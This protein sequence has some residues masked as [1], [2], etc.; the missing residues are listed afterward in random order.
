MYMTS[1]SIAA[2]L[3]CLSCLVYTVLQRRYEKLQG[4]L[5]IAIIVDVGITAISN[6]ITEIAGPLAAADPVAAGLQ[7]TFDYLYFIAHSALAPLFCVYV[8]VVCSGSLRRSKAHNIVFSAPFFLTEVFALLNPVLHWVYYYGPNLTYTR[9][10]AVYVIYAVGVVYFVAGLVWLLR[11]W[12]A[13]TPLKRRALSYFFIM[14]GIGVGVQLV[15]PLF[16][17]EL[18][19]ESL[20]IIGVMMFI[21][22]E[23]ELKDY[24]SGV[25]NRH[26]LEM[27]LRTYANTGQSFSVVAVRVVNADAFTHI[28]GSTYAAQFMAT[29]LSEYFKTLFPWYRIYRTN[30][31]RFVL[32]DPQ[33]SYADAEALAQAIAN[34]FK[35]SWEYHDMDIDLHAVV[36]LAR[37]PEDLPT[38]D[39]VFYLVDTPVPPVEGRDVL[40]GDD[41][42]YLMRRAEVERAVQRGLDEGNYEV[43]YQPIYDASE[44]AC[45]AEALM[46]LN[47]PVLGSV[48]PFE[49][50]EVAER[51]G[52]IEDIGEF[53][54]REVCAFIASGVP[55]SLGLRH[56]GVNLSVIQCMKA[57]F[58][59]HADQVVSSYG[60]EPH[61]VSFEI[62]ESVAAGD[63][64]FLDRVMGQLSETG[65]SFAMDDYGTGYSNMHSFIRLNFDVVKID[66]S[67][68]WDAEKSDMGMVI[69]E[70]NV[71]M[72]RNVG[73]QVLVEGVET[74]EQVALLHKLG[75]DYFQGFHFAKPMPKSELVSFLQ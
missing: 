13:V 41:L 33:M 19:A 10:W 12:R 15:N 36:A 59:A 4:K 47:D 73:C 70:N 69:L 68:L 29:T 50:I 17:I 24:E 34:R 53:A 27:D 30:P 67:V 43:Y 45:V 18:F 38:P 48:P 61:Q 46:R 8:L 16:R 28:G 31:A 62:T 72:L 23:D 51:M 22:N 32:V 3:V 21:E 6:V 71:N 65:H 58:P 7:M 20:A 9:N 25:Y 37:V 5:F 49:F 56:I 52:L 54:L 55:Q 60:I 42:N 2:M 11:H 66:K 40:K 57:D 35:E 26:A 63:Y 75:V 1:F 74:A 44:T 14:V 64:E 39:D